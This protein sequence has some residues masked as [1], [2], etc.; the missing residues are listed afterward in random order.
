M[1]VLGAVALVAIAARPVWAEPAGDS[2]KRYFAQ[3]FRID[4]ARITGVDGFKLPPGNRYGK[5]WL[6][7]YT[8]NGAAMSAVALSRCRAESCKNEAR[9][10][11]PG[12]L[13]F[14]GVVDLEGPPGP[15]TARD[16]V[17]LPGGLDDHPSPSPRARAGALVIRTREVRSSREP[18][19]SGAMV[20]SESVRTTLRLLSLQRDSNLP[21][22][23]IVVV[24]TVSVGGGQVTTLELVKGRDATLD[25][26]S[27]EQRRTLDGSGCIEP[28]P[29]VRTWQLTRDHYVA[30]ATPEP[31]RDGC[32]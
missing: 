24:D 5:A 8:N 12:K 16:M 20:N 9:Y 26:R 22:L 31:A 19:I 25:V 4:A 23:E 15:L 2:T 6:G 14:L 27:S 28:E 18:N 32:W 21:L 3:L 7:T 11:F 1:V 10:T 30:D 17:S 13:E 29:W